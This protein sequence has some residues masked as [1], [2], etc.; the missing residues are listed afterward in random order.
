MNKKD[1]EYIVNLLI[2]ERARMYNMIRMKNNIKLAEDEIRYIDD[3]LNRIT[4]KE[5][6]KWQEYQQL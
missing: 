4:N 3:L 2:E 6:L 1:R 5:V